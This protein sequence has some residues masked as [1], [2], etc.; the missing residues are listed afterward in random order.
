[1]TLHHSLPPHLLQTKLFLSLPTTFL[2][3]VL[4]V[5]S[6]LPLWE[7]Q[8]RANGHVSAR[9]LTVSSLPQQVSLF[10]LI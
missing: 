10:I 9:L 6:I 1:M 3:F 7:Q 8:E 2:A 5:L 4:P